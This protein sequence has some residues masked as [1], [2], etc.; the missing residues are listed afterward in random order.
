MV[1]FSKD[2]DFSQARL[3]TPLRLHTITHAAL[4]GDVAVQSVQRLLSETTLWYFPVEMQGETKAMLVVD[5]MPDGWRAVSFGYAPLAREWNVIARQW[6][7][8]KGFHPR[9][10]V[11]FQASQYCFTVPELDDQNLTPV[12]SATASGLK[13]PPGYTALG[14]LSD[15]VKTL[16]PV[17]AKA[18]VEP[19]PSN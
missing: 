3:G 14:A 19:R 16:R 1:G 18:V 5:R 6:P 10:V 17:V 13:P 8:A 9:L 11:V 7:T 15:T 4:A 12:A 2:N